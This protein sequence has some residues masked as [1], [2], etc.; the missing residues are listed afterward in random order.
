MGEEGQVSQ[1]RRPLTGCKA[2]DGLFPQGFQQRPHVSVVEAFGADDGAAGSAEA[3]LQE[4]YH[5]GALVALD[6]V[7]A[8]MEPRG[9]SA[10]WAFGCHCFKGVCGI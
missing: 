2:F 7:V 1:V 6:Q 5:A 8:E 4:G 10:E 3:A 9:V